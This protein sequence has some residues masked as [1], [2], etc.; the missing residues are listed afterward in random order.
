[1]KARMLLVCA[2]I[3]LVMSWSAS[4]LWATGSSLTLFH[5][6]DGESKLLGSGNF[7]GFD[8]FLHEL[9][10]ART[11]ASATRDVLTISSG[12]NILAGL[13]LQASKARVSDPLNP[14]AGGN[15]DNY[16]DALALVAA[17]YDAITLGNH[18]FDDGPD[19]L[20]SFIKGYQNA[21]G[22]AS[23]LSSNLDFSGEPALNA[24]VGSGPGQIA[25][26]TI[27][28]GTS[29]EKY[30]IIGVTTPLIPI[31]SQPGGVTP[32]GPNL[33]DVAAAINAQVTDLT[34]NHGVNKIILSGHL[35]SLGEDQALV[36]LLSGVDVI[37]AGGG[38]ELLRNGPD[39]NTSA[40]FGPAIEG[41][42]PVISTNNDLDGRKVALV[43]T[44]GEYRYVGQLDVD[45]DM[46]GFVT[47]AG[48][49][50]FDANGQV[51]G[52]SLT[53]NPILVNPLT[54][55]AATGVFNG[56]DVQ[57]DIMTPLTTDIAI[58][59][60]SVVGTTQ[61][62]LDGRNPDPIRLRESGLG[63][64]VGE[65]FI[66]T[67]NQLADLSDAPVI[68]VTNGGGIRNNNVFP[69]G[70]NL[71]VANIISI[72]PFANS[73]SVIKNL[74][75]QELLD[76]MNYSLDPLPG[77]NGRFLQIAGFNVTYD[78]FNGDDVVSI[79]LNDGTPLYNRVQGILYG[80]TLNLV[81]NS[82]T[83]GG[84]DGYSM[85]GAKPSIDLGVNYGDALRQF[86]EAPVIDGGLGGVILAADYPTNGQGLIVAIPTPAALPA[87]LIALA[88]ILARRRR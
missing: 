3:A 22:T 30:G 34:T 1:M 67:A 38:D 31:I 11:A 85:F 24:L 46:N 48:G 53:G 25:A 59:A 21:G 5:N 33:S 88:G 79:A 61:V 78:P 81:T 41:P 42:Y 43:T 58:L 83:A 16:Y 9:D 56:V 71:T 40:S 37:I 6:N 15:S 20:A 76:A 4:S 44:Q 72:L 63:N 60:A 8:H 18:E 10:T 62:D 26:S 2:C 75:V 64:L 54:S 29:G 73:V 13:A 50:T 55:P 69:A 12:D 39:A 84:G 86:I 14:G 7:G 32:T 57:A 87:G 49:I 68:A 66:F 23:F 51:N 74:T 80:G 28:T 70:T 47:S 77:S 36:S 27:V 17:G 52:V 35:Q 65:A 19:F 45:F 82:F